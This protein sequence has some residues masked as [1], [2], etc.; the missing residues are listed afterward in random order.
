[1]A[2]ADR[3]AAGAVE[4][5]KALAKSMLNALGYR[6]EGIRYT[7]RQL[8]DPDR[9]RTVEF[10]D[11][12]CR[13]IVE[14]GRELTFIQV[15]VFDGVTNDPLRKYIEQG[16]LRGV[17]V[18]PQA[19]SAD[20]LRALYAGTDRISV[21]QAAVD[22]QRGQRRLFTIAS[23]TAPQWAGGLAS[24]D[25]AIVLKHADLVPGLPEMIRE[26]VVDCVTFDD[27]LSRL[28]AGGLDLLQIDA[29]GADAYILSLFP[30]DRMKPAIIH[31]EVKHLSKAERERCLDQLASLGYR[32]AVSGGEDMVAVQS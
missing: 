26:E 16:R 11:V 6:I 12:L 32:F 9:L 18:E 3:P 4:K 19:R 1:M 22:R 15:G 14:S 21:L 13:R 20:R 23:E 10:D 7:P 5:L 28:P 8:L 25:R 2:V 24:F 29:E 17:L 30:F 31:W 27:V